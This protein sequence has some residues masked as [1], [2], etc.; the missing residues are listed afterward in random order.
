MILVKKYSPVADE[1]E[2]DNI[3]KAMKKKVEPV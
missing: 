2:E 1:W 3:G